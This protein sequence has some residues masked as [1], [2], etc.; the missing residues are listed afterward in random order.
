MDDLLSNAYDE[1]YYA[2]GLGYPVSRTREW[3]AFFDRIAYNIQEGINP[4]SVL[5]AGCAMGLLVEVLRN[6]GIETFGIDISEYAIGQVIP[7]VKPFC[8]VASILDPFPRRYDLIVTIEVL[9]HIPANLAEKAIANLCAHTDDVLFSSTPL[10]FN[11]PSHIN[12]QPVEHWAELFARQ[13]FFRDMDFDGSFLTPWAIRFRKQSVTVTRLVREYERRDWRIWKEN[14]DLRKL[15]LDMRI[16]QADQDRRLKDLENQK[17]S[18]E[19]QLMSQAPLLEDLRAQLD[20]R[21]EQ[22]DWK[23][24]AEA[25]NTQ[26]AEVLN[27]RT[28]RWITR[29]KR[30]FG[31]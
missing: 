20:E 30:L 1:Y 31:I 27:S 2:T 6:R 28:W 3:L 17:K 19:G 22:A 24:Q 18:L 12:A 8:Q 14:A 13:G 11:E 16:I 26:L 23:R 4:T 5:D 9:E 10:D 29:F 25:A 15:S 7:E 21:F